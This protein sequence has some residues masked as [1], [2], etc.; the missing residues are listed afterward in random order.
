MTIDPQI[1]HDTLKP[2]TVYGH[3]AGSE[4]QMEPLPDGHYY[5]RGEVDDLVKELLERIALLN[6]KNARLQADLDW[7]FRSISAAETDQLGAL[8]YKLCC[9]QR[10][11]VAPWRDLG[12][13][14][15][16]FSNLA[17]DVVA[18]FIAERKKVLTP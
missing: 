1:L 7:M 6:A 8:V 11:M 10:T 5:L 18:T 14:G 4:K 3:L 2:L 9:P 13:Y 17:R 16:Q 12:R 15:E